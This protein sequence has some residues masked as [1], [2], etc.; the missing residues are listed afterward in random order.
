[1]ATDVDHKRVMTIGKAMAQNAE[2]F[3]FDLCDTIDIGNGEQL[4]IYYRE[5][6]DKDSKARVDQVYIEFDQCDRQEVTYEDAKGEIH[7]IPGGFKD[8]R[9]KDGVP[10]DLDARVSI[11][12]WG[13]EKYQRFLAAGGPPGLILMT[14][15]RM[16]QQFME[17]I[18]RDPK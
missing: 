7:T 18:N 5:L 17:R 11:A 4:D 10:F 6:L 1:M 16:R 15:T 13:E 3:G 2:Y 9:V 12:L 8:P 14:W